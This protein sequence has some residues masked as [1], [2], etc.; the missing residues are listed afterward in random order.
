[1][2]AL[3][4]LR[5]LLE[6]PGTMRSAKSR[7]RTAILDQVAVKP[8]R[9]LLELPAPR[10][11]K[12]RK[13]AP[14]AWAVAR[15]QVCCCRRRPRHRPR[16]GAAH[17]RSAGCAPGCREALERPVAR[18]RTAYWSLVTYVWRAVPGM[19]RPI[20]P[21]FVILEARLSPVNR[22][23]VPLFARS[24]HSAM[25]RKERSS[26]PRTAHSCPCVGRGFAAVQKIPKPTTSFTRWPKFSAAS[27]FEH[28]SAY[29]VA[30]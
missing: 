4:S 25:R 3:E 14:A 5:T 21:R 11:V 29:R 26:A 20:R 7:P 23:G 17:R 1:M 10:K 30:R 27:T 22:L 24:T 9:I 2:R 6:L 12:R 28:A 16:L 13:S 15:W 8:L 18:R 19:N